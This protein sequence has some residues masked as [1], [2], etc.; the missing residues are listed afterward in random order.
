MV[1]GVNCH[2][3][4]KQ[5]NQNKSSYQRRPKIHDAFLTHERWEDTWGSG[6]VGVKDLD[7]DPTPKGGRGA[8][9]TT[10]QTLQ[11]VFARAPPSHCSLEK[12]ESRWALLKP[13]IPSLTPTPR[14]LK[15]TQI[16]DSGL[17]PKLSLILFC[18]LFNRKSSNHLFVFA[19]SVW[20]RATD[21]WPDCN[22][23]WI[24]VCYG[25]HKFVSG[26][27]VQVFK[28]LVS[29]CLRLNLEYDRF[30]PM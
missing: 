30:Y 12:S 24:L 25:C 27:C 3:L 17:D 18:D 26:Q 1:T 16:G 9:Q 21:P 14:T 2:D 8:P 19:W 7:R 15:A 29:Q 5:E 6:G 11:L 10:T 23:K 28:C 22:V 4:K 13:L 20:C